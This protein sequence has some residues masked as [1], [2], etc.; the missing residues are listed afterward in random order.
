MLHAAADMITMTT[1]IRAKDVLQLNQIL[2]AGS[3]WMN[4]KSELML[5]RRATAYSSYCS[6]V[7]LIYLHPFRRSSLFCSQKSPKITKNLILGFNVI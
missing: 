5:I 2:F 1:I 7:V 6:Q 4:K 3:E